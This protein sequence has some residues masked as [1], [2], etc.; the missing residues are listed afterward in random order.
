[1]P[2]RGVDGGVGRGTPFV[3]VGMGWP[4]TSPFKI[5]LREINMFQLIVALCPHIVSGILVKIGSNDGSL[6]VRRSAI[7]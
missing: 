6:P 4:G 3:G 2:P 7:S 5:F 1:M